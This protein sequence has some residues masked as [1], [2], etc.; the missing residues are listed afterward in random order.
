MAGFILTQYELGAYPEFVLLL[1]TITGGCVIPHGY[2][3]LRMYWLRPLFGLKPLPRR[4]A[5]GSGTIP[6]RLADL[7]LPSG[8]CLTLPAC[9]NTHR[10]SDH[11]DWGIMSER[12]LD[13]ELLRIIAAWLIVIYHSKTAIHEVSYSGL[14]AF[15]EIGIFFAI[16]GNDK[17]YSQ[18]ITRFLSRIVP[19]YLVWYLCYGAANVALGKTILPSDENGIL[20]AV[21][22]G[23]SGHLWYIPFV[24]FATGLLLLIPLRV[25]EKALPYLAV[26]G[27]VFLAVYLPEWRP[28]SLEKGEPVAQWVHGSAAVLFAVCIA[29]SNRRIAMATAVLGIAMFIRMSFQSW[30]GVGIPYLVGSVAVALLILAGDKTKGLKAGKLGAVS[31]CMAGVY[32]IHIFFLE[33]AERVVSMNFLV[34]SACFLL[35]TAAVFAGYT[36]NKRA[37]R[38]VFG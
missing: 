21:L 5:K 14:I 3:I 16:S 24:I 4:A 27:L 10:T 30:P 13:I 29:A 17:P 9:L 1:L 8:D 32:F 35:S 18:S 12:R 11:I 28:W 20:G 22:M 2:L 26:I 33:A 6:A 31:Q 19:P 15:I 25:R 23:P 7:P 38:L 36:V 37:A 34:A